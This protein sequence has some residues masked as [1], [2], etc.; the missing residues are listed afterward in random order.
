MGHLQRH[1]IQVYAVKLFVENRG[2]TIRQPLLLFDV[3][4]RCCMSE[5]DVRF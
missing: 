5:I 2:S 3:H 4:G 1:Q